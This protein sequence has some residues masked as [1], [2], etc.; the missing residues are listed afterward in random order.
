MSISTQPLP[1]GYILTPGDPSP[2]SYVNLRVKTG[3]TP[4]TVAQALAG[5]GGAWC[6]YHI[7]HEAT[8]TAV[9]MGRVISDGGR[10]FH[11]I[12]MATLPNHQRKGLGRVILSSLLEEIETRASP[13]AHMKLMADPPGRSLYRKAGF[14]ETGDK[15]I[16]MAMKLSGA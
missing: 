9:S 3:L 2:E 16:G 5:N 14:K 6:A 7:I 13:G 8:S 1:E 12:D 11:V 10:Q 15:S 4:P